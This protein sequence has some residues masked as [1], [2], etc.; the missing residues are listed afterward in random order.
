M[1]TDRET[2]VTI[3]PA[4]FF[5]LDFIRDLSNE[6]FSQYGP[7]DRILT[8]WFVSGT[9]IT[10]LALIGGTPVGFA[11]IRP[12]D[13]KAYYELVTELVAIAVEPEKQGCGIG[14]LLMTEVLRL[15]DDM[16]VKAMT[17]CT[18]A[19]N[20][21]AQE[22]FEKHGFETL[23]VEKGYYEGGQGAVVMYRVIS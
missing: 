4:G 13:E 20:K 3:R 15:A 7:Y 1:K 22:L 9:T 11:M 23:R 6:V 14:D 18:G 10:R 16:Q 5:D 2:D 8:D 21:P 12:P 19:D 17:L